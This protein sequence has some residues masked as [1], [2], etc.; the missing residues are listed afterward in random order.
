MSDQHLVSHFQ[1]GGTKTF[2][3]YQ[4]TFQYLFCTIISKDLTRFSLSHAQTDLLYT[5]AQCDTLHKCE[6]LGYQCMLTLSLAHSMKH[7]ATNCQ[8]VRSHRV[9][10]HQIAG[11]QTAA[12]FFFFFHKTQKRWT[13]KKWQIFVASRLLSVTDINH[14]KAHLLIG[15]NTALSILSGHALL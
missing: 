13:W 3:L 15:G 10:S 14:A 6:R 12:T 4:K 5:P 7:L 8:D 9:H 1:K 11:I 2:T